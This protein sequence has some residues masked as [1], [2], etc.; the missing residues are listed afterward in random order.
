MATT[1]RTHLS[2]TQVWC[3]AASN[4]DS[5]LESFS[6]LGEGR[7]EVP[8]PQPSANEGQELDDNQGQELSQLLYPIKWDNSEAH[9]SPSPRF[10]QQDRA[11]GCPLG[12]PLMLIFLL[13]P[14]FP[15]VFPSPLAMFSLDYFSNKLLFSNR[16][17]VHAGRSQPKTQ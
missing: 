7:P 9:T 3:Q 17:N 11:P 5:S 10:P 8:L 1:L 6:W 15:H 4:Y 14:S 2:R 16:L 12:Q 13:Y